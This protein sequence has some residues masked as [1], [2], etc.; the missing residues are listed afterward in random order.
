MPERAKSASNSVPPPVRP[1]RVTSKDVA[2]RAGV[3]QPTVST[4]LSNSGV[5]KY[6]SDATRQRVLA[7]AAELGYQPNQS[8]RTMRTGRFGSVAVLTST[9]PNRGSI[10]DPGMEGIHAELARHDQ[11]LMMLR[12]PDASLTD[13][14]ALPRI[15]REWTVDGLLV[16]LS[17]DVPPK[18]IELIRRHHIPAVWIN[19][20]Q[21]TDCVRPDDEEGGHMAAQHF[22][23]LGHTRIAYVSQP[24]EHYSVAHRERGYARAMRKAGLQ[25]QIFSIDTE[26]DTLKEQ[27]GIVQALLTSP[28]RP[29]AFIYYASEAAEM[30]YL[31]ARLLGLQVPGDISMLILAPTEHFR[32]IAIRLD[33]LVIPFQE[34]GELAVQLLMKKIANPYFSSPI[35]KVPFTLSRGESSQ[36]LHHH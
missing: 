29:T 25:P 24:G 14:V 13:E 35:K 22:L 16:G 20:D 26:R 34:V 36:P 10:M 6:V 15:L 23:D 18:M 11:H 8:A 3:G 12:L 1:K 33:T 17:V 9:V 19:S 32:C 5:G 30:T 2:A 7:A 31:V 4:V 21:E 27:F 28:D